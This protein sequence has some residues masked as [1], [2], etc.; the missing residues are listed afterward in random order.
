MQRATGAVLYVLATVLLVAGLWW[1][2]RSAPDIGED[3]QV[4]AWRAAAE[5][6][7]PDRSDQVNARTE[8]VGPG[9]SRS[10]GGDASPGRYQLLL[11]CAGRGQ[12][13]VQLRTPDG[14][15]ALDGAVPC[16]DDPAPVALAVTLAESSY[17][18]DFSAEAQVRVVLRWRLGPA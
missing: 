11:A 16:A 14:L 5:A 8:V 1:W 4:V 15:D 13:R 2:V 3:P 12:I 18:M 6:I 7:V 9:S 10:V 17:V